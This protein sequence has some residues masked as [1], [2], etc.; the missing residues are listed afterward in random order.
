M[1]FPT[2]GLL[3]SPRSVLPF[4]PASRKNRTSSHIDPE[5]ALHV[6]PVLA[7]VGLCVRDSRAHCTK[8]RVCCAA[9]SEAGPTTEP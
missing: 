1:D 3:R 9:G 6:L 4:A 8:K 7:F 2:L 5:A